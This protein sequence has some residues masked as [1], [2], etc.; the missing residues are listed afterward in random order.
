MFTI[1]SL[2]NTRDE[3]TKPLNWTQPHRVGQKSPNLSRMNKAEVVI[4]N[5]GGVKYSTSAGTLKRYQ[6]SKL[7]RALEGGDPDFRIA[8]GQIF[9]DRDGSLFRYI[10]DF[11]R[12]RQL[13]LPSAFSDYDRL[14]REAEF[15]N[16][17]FLV[18]LLNQDRL[19]QRLEIL[20]VRY[21]LQETYSFF[22][23]FCSCNST[24]ETLA[25]R[26]MVFAEQ[27]GQSWDHSSVQRPLVPIPLQRPSHHDLVFQCGTDYSAGDE[28]STRYVSI[29][30]DERKLINGSNVLGL[31]IDT[32]LR[33]GFCLIS[34]RTV[35]PTEKIECYTFERNRR[36]EHLSTSNGQGEASTNVVHFQAKKSQF[37]RR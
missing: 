8:N 36:T 31:L 33:E 27:P 24:I 20:E 3:R 21:S 11:L 6:D 12:T 10:L 23:V 28:F 16:L 18:E 25:G 32:L 37:R 30:P 14:A 5:I 13:D 22:R 29:R 17:P 2:G 9:V 35:S 19:K 4:L 34:T 15:Y 1:G 7:A 26:I